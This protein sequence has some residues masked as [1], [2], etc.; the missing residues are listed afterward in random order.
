MLAANSCCQKLEIVVLKRARL[1]K[2]LREMWLVGKLNKLSRAH[3]VEYIGL[4]PPP[5]QRSWRVFFFIQREENLI[6]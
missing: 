6:Q 2:K 4:D 1:G 5:R 3:P